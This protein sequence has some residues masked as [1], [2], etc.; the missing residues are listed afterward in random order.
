LNIQTELPRN[1]IGPRLALIAAAFEAAATGILLLIRPS[2]VTWLVFGVSELTGVSQAL[3]RIG[4]IAMLAGA[5]A[6]WPAPEATDRSAGARAFALYNLLCFAYLAYL[7]AGEA[8]SGILLWPA[9]VFHAALAA[10][11]GR[12]WLGYA[13]Q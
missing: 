7:G 13:Q 12:I 5:L 11:L 1:L 8:F 2:L 10:L 6:A 3:G 4:G 9:V